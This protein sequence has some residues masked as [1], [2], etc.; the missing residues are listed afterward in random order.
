ME[1]RIAKE[2]INMVANVSGIAF[3]NPPIFRAYLVLH[4]KHELQN[5]N[6]KQTSFEKSV[7]LHGK[8]QL[9]SA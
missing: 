1:L 9:H 6:L 3:S 2:A 8:Q 4:V 7:R 5:Q